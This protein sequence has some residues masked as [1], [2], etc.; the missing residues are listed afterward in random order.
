[1]KT[2]GRGEVQI[3]VFFTLA[4]VGGSGQLHT[5]VTLP[6]SP[7]YPLDRKLGRA[8]NRSGEHGKKTI[9]NLPGLK[10]QTLGR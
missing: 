7:R 9:L 2:Y 8:Q 4:L 10:L 1:M 3:H 5:P 6:K